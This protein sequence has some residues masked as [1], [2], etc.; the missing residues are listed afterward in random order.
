[1]SYENFN[2]PKLMEAH[3]AEMHAFYLNSEIFFLDL[4]Q[5]YKRPEYFELAKKMGRLSK[6]LKISL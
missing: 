2:H 6:E 1:M 5:K 4:Y 3:D